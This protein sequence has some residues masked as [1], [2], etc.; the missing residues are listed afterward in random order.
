VQVRDRLVDIRQ[1][2]RHRR[3]LAVQL[4]DP[5]VLGAHD[6]LQVL[7][8]VAHLGRGHGHE[9]PVV[10]PGV[11]E[12]VD[13]RLQLLIEPAHLD[14]PKAEP[15]ALA[16]ACKHAP[17]AGRRRGGYI[18]GVGD[19]VA[20]LTVA[21]LLDP[22]A[23][24]TRHVAHHQVRRGVE[25]LD[26]KSGLVVD[27]ERERPRGPAHAAASEP[28]FG[29][30]EQRGEQ[31]GIVLRLEEA[32]VSSRIAVALEMQAVDLGADPPDRLLAPERQPVGDLGMLEIRVLLRIEVLQ[33]LEQ[34]RR[35]PVRVARVEARR[36]LQELLERAPVLDRLDAQG[37]RQGLDPLRSTVRGIRP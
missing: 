29:R 21:L 10:R 6:R 3:R 27:R 14:R 25:P 20:H 11:V 19:Q 35:Y 1:G 17:G 26:Q 32:E 37:R 7:A 9:A 5:G 12:D 2:H 34:Q 4:A 24:V 28:L 23:V 33:A 13:D 36:H 8:H 22:G 18:E 31:L 30:F 15:G 16:Q